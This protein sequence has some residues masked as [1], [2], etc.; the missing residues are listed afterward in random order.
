MQEKLLRGSIKKKTFAIFVLTNSFITAKFGK[1]N[2]VIVSNS[3][4][5]KNNFLKSF[6]N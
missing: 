6:Q 1:H 3:L 4:K 5:S 2:Y